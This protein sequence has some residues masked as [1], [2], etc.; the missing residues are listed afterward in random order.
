MIGYGDNRKGYRLY[1]VQKWRIMYSPDVVF[2]EMSVGLEKSE[3]ESKLPDVRID[4]SNDDESMDNEIDT[5]KSEVPDHD[6]VIQ[7][8]LDNVEEPTI[9]HSTRA[10]KHP[11]HYDVWVY[12]TNECEL[13]TVE[14]ALTGADKDKW[15]NAMDAE[16]ESITSHNVWDFVE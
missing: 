16:Y 3:A 2:N 1:D 11:D 12:V 5:D 13:T 9:R 10:R 7:Q 4:C 15:K 8:E 6:G 14:E